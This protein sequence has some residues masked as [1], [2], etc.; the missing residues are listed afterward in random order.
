MGIYFVPKWMKVLSPVEDEHFFIAKKKHP[1]AKI[2]NRWDS[3]ITKAGI[4]GVV[5]TVQWHDDWNNNYGGPPVEGLMA[6]ATLP[7]FFYLDRDMVA[8]ERVLTPEEEKWYLDTIQEYL[9]SIGIKWEDNLHIT[10]I[11]TALSDDNTYWHYL[12]SHLEKCIIGI[13]IGKRD[14]F[15]VVEEGNYAC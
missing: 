7:M 1:S 12:P 6:H 4:D 13:D 5:Q 11:G 9:T 15:L 8:N 2:G 14:L 3:D 10:N